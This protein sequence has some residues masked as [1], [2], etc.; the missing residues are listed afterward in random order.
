M[1]LVGEAHIIVRAITNQV[2]KDIQ[3]AFKDI[4]ATANRA[5][6]DAAS[7]F[8]RGFERR[9]SGNNVFTR[10][11][12]AITSMVPGALAARAAFQSMVRTGYTLGTTISVLV[13][14]IFSLIGGLGALVGAAGGAAASLAVVGNSVFA[15]AAGMVATRLA[16]SGVGAA[17][18]R[19]NR[20]AAGGTSSSRPASTRAAEASQAAA[21]EA[22]IAAAERVRDAEED[23]ARTIERNRERMLDANNAVREAQLALNQAIADGREE[24]Q[25]IGFE[26]EDAALAEQE[27]AL[28]LARAREA[29]QRVQDLPP[30]NRARQAAELAYQQAELNLRKAQD[31][32]ADL[33]DE[34]D[35]L[36][37]TGVKGTDAYVKASNELAEAEEDR[38][39]TTR[40]AIQDEADARK[41]LTRAQVDQ[42]KAG[43]R[44]AA[45]DERM[46]DAMANPGVAGQAWDEGLNAAQRKF[47]LFIASLKPQFDELERIAAEAFLPRLQR[48]IETLME[49]AYPV[50]AVGIG[51]VAAAMG[52][53]AITIANAITQ[54]QALS[55]LATLFATSAELLRTLGSI[56]GSIWQAS[57]AILVG[58][59]PTA[60]RFFD[61]LDDRMAGF[62]GVMQRMEADGS[63][64]AFFS[65][66]GD[67]AAKFGDIFGNIFGGFGQ[68]IM[69]N[70]GP[71]TGGWMMLE[72]LQEATQK[73]ADLG[74]TPAKMASLQDFF[75]GVSDNTKAIS[76]SIGELLG[77]LLALGDNPA[78]GETFRIL[79]RGAPALV[80][81]VEKSIEAGPALAT[82]VVQITELINKLTETGAI[83]VFFDTLA[84]FAATFNNV[85]GNDVVNSI[86]TVTGRVFALISAVGLVGQI[87]LFGFKALAGMV[88]NTAG[89][90]GKLI[91]GVS[92]LGS[93]FG[94]V[95]TGGLGAGLKTLQDG[96]KQT[97]SD[98]DDLIKNLGL[99]DGKVADTAAKT[100]PLAGALAGLKG[101]FASVT[102]AVKTGTATAFA[103]IGSAASTAGAGIAAFGRVLMGV[104]LGPVGIVIGIIGL[105]VAAFIGL[106]NTNDQFRKDMDAAWAEISKALS[107][108]GSEIMAALR[109]LMDTFAELV[110]VFASVFAQ[111]ITS[112][113]PVISMIVRQLVPVFTMVINAIAP[114]ITMIVSAF[115]PVITAIVTALVPLI[116]ALI[117]ILVPVIQVVINVLSFLIQIFVAVLKVVIEV[118]TNVIVFIV[119]ALTVVIREVTNF[120]RDFGTGWNNFWN[121]IFSIIS[122]VWK[123]ITDAL[124]KAWKW[125]DTYIFGPIRTAVQWVADAFDF[126]GK[127]IA[128][129]WQMMQDQLFAVFSWIDTYVFG[130]I[131][132]AVDLVQQAFENVA[133]GIAT[134]WDGIKKAAAVPINFVIDTVYNN[135]LRSFWNDIAGNL[136]MNDMKLPRVPTIAFASGGVMPGYSPGKDIHKFYSPTGG[137]LHLSG[138]EAIMRPEWTRAVGGPAA[139]ARMNARARRGQ[140]FANGGVFNGGRTQ[141]FAS[142]GVVD[143]VGD[144][145]ENLGKVAEIIGDFFSDP[146]GAV[147]KH[148]VDGLIKPLS[149]GAG[150]NMFS[151]LVTGVPV[152]VASWLGDTITNFF[153]ADG[154][155]K[156]TAGMGWQAMS[157]LVKQA[158]PG[159]RITSAYRPGSVTVNGSPSYHGSGR[160]I[161]V[162]PATMATFN[163]MLR[164]FPNAR[165]LIFSPAGGRQLLN[166]KPHL[167]GGK[168]RDTHWDHVHAAMANGGTVFPSRGGSIVQVA[169]AGRAERIE[170]LHPNGLSDRDLALIDRLA[171]D[172]GDVKIYIDAKDGKSAREVAEEV[173][174]ILAKKR[175]RGGI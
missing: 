43:D 1:A 44:V 154:A 12:R 9:F 105:L 14:G 130:P 109:P 107:D 125:I 79:E 77:G 61:F 58:A 28:E 162:V 52:D 103:S 46:A 78:I 6:Q 80:S 113:A 86:L 92:T 38:V 36:A 76:Q 166:G 57:L 133:D 159:A 167:W 158:I 129:A 164:L 73:F 24:I 37:R 67:M 54:G 174:E 146:K 142:G 27:A 82:L 31:R 11:A 3:N 99:F 121:F 4:N 89:N 33:A 122:T 62:A 83:E 126:A 74:D 116:T 115:V 40:D 143:F 100:T 153:G 56:L 35:R 155:P 97:G 157:A 68:I 119:N 132:D 124:N 75:R 25:Q 23:L 101:G 163:Q 48:A 169:E 64:A 135:G 63:L 111:I 127:V 165:E 90:I 123:N 172:P 29:L 91:G 30:N 70:F 84:A 65:T 118:M 140:A 15:I 81:I 150:D 104:L 108:A 2:Q 117:N 26:A 134:A 139:V 148:I 175:R 144:V 60:Q 49:K 10:M 20:Q 85:L 21:R 131:R 51:Q 55:N 22:E 5:G 149:A 112:I 50:V 147:Q 145:F 120:I 102:G 13:G 170:P 8:S 42:A 69:A 173:S 87:A 47:A 168:V 88:A 96:F 19:L 71:G 45:A 16:L 41:A 93:A 59:A 171:G 161:D 7:S 34:Q 137:I 128:L 53:A 114:L 66:A 98:K 94:A 156:G 138:G 17:V 18:S 32:A 141:R 110:T 95:R 106:Y 136:G 151:K 160:A 39:R 152:K 72:W